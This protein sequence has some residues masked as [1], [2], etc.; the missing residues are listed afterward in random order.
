MTGLGGVQGRGGMARSKAV[1]LWLAGAVLV[2]LLLVFSGHFILSRTSAS[3]RLKELV[4]AQICGATGGQV[5]FDRLQVELLPHPHLTA[6]AISIQYPGI[7]AGTVQ[8]LVIVP[9]L[10]PLLSGR[11]EPARL[12]L[13]APR[14]ELTIPD[15]ASISPPAPALQGDSEPSSIPADPSA[16]QQD[17][18]SRD[19]ASEGALVTSAY[20]APLP[21][22]RS[23]FPWI[24]RLNLEEP[25]Y[26]VLNTLSEKVPGLELTAEQGRLEVVHRGQ[27]LLSLRNLSLQAIL[28]PHVMV[29]R[30]GGQSNLWEELAVNSRFD[31]V[32][33]QG[34]GHLRIRQCRSQLLGE[35][36]PAGTLKP[37]GESPV[38]LEVAFSSQ[39]PGLL[40][41]TIHASSPSLS[42]QL[43]G[44][45]A[46]F[47]D[48]ALEA[49]V[50]TQGERFEL[51]LDRLHAEAPQLDLT[52]RLWSHPDSAEAAYRLECRN[53][54]AAAV[55]EVALALGSESEVVQDVFTFIRGG[56]VPLV[57]FEARGRS[58]PALQEARNL[59]VTGRLE[60][61]EVFIPEISLTVTEVFGDVLIANGILAGNNLQG[62][63]ERSV[64]R[65]GSLT[66]A[67]M[68]K[69][70]PFHLDLEIDADLAR[71]PPIL[72]RVV[73]HRAF[74]T[75][76]A[77]LR[78]VTGAA[79][80]RLILDGT[81]DSIKTRAEVA[82]WDLAALHERLPFPVA[83]RAG[84]LVYEGHEL[85]VEALQGSLGRSNVSDLSG[86]LTW[87][88][89]L[90]FELAGPAKGRLLLGE[91]FPWL[92][93][94]TPV[95]D[96]PWKIQT[97]EGAL[98][99]HSLTFK[100]PLAKPDRWQFALTGRLQN[101]TA[102]SSL[103]EDPLKINSG[104]LSWTP[105]RL[106]LTSWEFTLVDA[107]LA[108]SGKLSN[109][110]AES[111]LAD[112]TFQGTLGPQAGAWLGELGE[113]PPELRLRA[114]LTLTQSRFLRDRSGRTALSGNFRTEEGAELVFDLER[115]D[116]E[117]SI[118]QLKV[119]DQ[120]SRAF[121]TL[122]LK[123]GEVGCSFQG[124]L[125]SRTLDRLL[126]T[127]HFFKGRI[128]GD[129]NL[130]L[131]K[132]HLADSRA[133]GKLIISDFSY[134]PVSG[135]VLVIEEAL[136]EGRGNAVEIKSAAMRLLDEP[137]KLKGTMTA[138]ESRL[139]LDWQIQAQGLDWD[140]LQ[141]ENHLG[142]L[143]TS[144]FGGTAG[145]GMKFLGIPLG[146][147]LRLQ[148]DHLT[149]AHFT[150]QPFWATFTLAPDGLTVDI[151]RSNL[152]TIPTPAKLIPHPTG[153]VLIINP[154]ARNLDLDATLD[155]LFDRKGT[156]TGV[157]DLDGELT[158]TVQSERMI[159]TLQG[160]L[161]LDARD[162]CV[163]HSPVL[164]KI[165]TLLNVTEIYRGQLP[166]LTQ[167]GCVYDSIDVGGVVKNGR[168]LIA[169]AVFD[170]HCAKMVWTGEI[171]LA[172]LT[173]DFT[174]LVSP[175]KTVDTVIRSI[176]FLGNILGGTLVTIPVRVVGD[177]RDPSVVTLPP[178][179]VGAGL[180]NKMKKLL[181]F[182]FTLQQ[183]LP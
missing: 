171:D 38:D 176:P 116:G 5:A 82:E 54:D 75:E 158:T 84:G 20:P 63:A 151:T 69:T 132:D 41:A 138:G 182:P 99:L 133:E 144:V 163:Y 137:M 97:L 183:P 112:L 128:A 87:N 102:T 164:S 172:A 110:L 91:I 79:S 161:D 129:L 100:G 154:A 108:V 19:S 126:A 93:S 10:L 60:K 26:S 167:E 72:A 1:G 149:L 180:L 76:L 55:R 114:P 113:V 73:D 119:Q 48:I 169:D 86:T 18:Q 68:D 70:G 3:E 177:I 120:E 42:L 143:G 33:S 92:M 170:G 136:L 105:Q 16:P 52:G 104:E 160:K 44:Q 156:I 81:M 95:R 12:E 130:Q 57:S 47:R 131:F 15:D 103:F 29:L 37:V 13:L 173:V 166:N 7:L 21:M 121:I 6:S 106:D 155:C 4:T 46:V 124:E 34:T 118:R 27:G 58:L 24:S 162:G 98:E 23:D 125:T 135:K 175:F 31:L 117:L 35:L 14:L 53:A 62:R 145:D 89:E 123:P 11:F 39:G 101:V 77:R 122:N 140:R 50:Q 22:A 2:S 142:H 85:T 32:E 8:S 66:V 49:L 141:D 43:S 159:E 71:L 174:V 139:L 88:R 148:A 78:D 40:Q 30:L 107:S 134:L 96:N 36:L 74:L 179:A 56:Q 168:V 181:Q 9:K 17:R 165:F 146:G 127:N 152:C 115:G 25:L 147:T 150:W 109:L 178:T 157:F 61:G 28:P 65:N 51:R 67:L 59:V 83:L 153:S 90:T 111:P 94:F 80:G 64:G 45:T